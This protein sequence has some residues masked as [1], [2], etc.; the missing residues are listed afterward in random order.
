MSIDQ[1]ATGVAHLIERAGLEPRHITAV[2]FTN[3]AAKEMQ[4]RVEELLGGSARG[5][6]LGTFH[7]ICA[8]IL[9]REANHLPFEQNFVIFDDDDQ[10]GLVKQ[11]I[12]EM[13]LN[14]VKGSGAELFVVDARIIVSVGR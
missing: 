3:K 13:D 6:S 12:K 4:A 9:R 8:R 2:T 7:G 11:A 5:I 14:P 10:R 1:R